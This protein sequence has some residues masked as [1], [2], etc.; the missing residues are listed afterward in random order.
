MIEMAK[1]FS[2]GIKFLRV[3]FYIVNNN[4]LFGELTFFPGG[5]FSKF[6]PNDADLKL[7][8]LLNIKG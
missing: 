4:V 5:G 6:Y 2:Y 8:N 3:D 1:K 7:G